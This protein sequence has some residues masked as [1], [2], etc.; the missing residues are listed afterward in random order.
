MRSLRDRI[1]RELREH[2][3]PLCRE[4]TSGQG[5]CR[6]QADEACTLMDRLDEIMEVI[7]SIRDYSIDPYQERIRRI[8]CSDCDEGPDGTCEQRDQGSCALDAHF[9]RIVAIIEKELA[10]DSGVA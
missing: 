2:I 5:C 10:A 4:A 8:I 7:S 9:P 1:E 6:G 3:C